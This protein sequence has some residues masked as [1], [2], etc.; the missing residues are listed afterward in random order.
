MHRLF[1]TL[2][3]AAALG[4]GCK[5]EFPNPFASPNPTATP[6][7]DAAVLLTS[8]GYGTAPGAPRDVFAVAA[9]GSG[10]SRL[11]FC[12]TEGRSCDAV[13]A[14]AAPDRAR[15]VVRRATDSNGDGRLTDADDPALVFMDLARGVEAPIVPATARVSGIDWSSQDET[16]FYSAVGAGGLEDL[17]AI[18]TNGQN[19]RALTSSSDA[20]ERRP[21]VNASG[22]ALALE[23]SGS[24]GKT[25]VWIG[26]FGSGLTRVTT[27]GPGSEPLTGTPYV[28]GSDA[29][30]AHS[31]DGRALAFRRLTGTGAGGLGTWDIL[32]VALDGSSPSVIASG[33]SYRGAPD[34]GPLGIVFEEIGQDGA[35]ALVV[36]QPGGS[37]RRTLVTLG[38][39]FRLSFPRWLT[40]R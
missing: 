26:V 23:R 29:D 35:P 34:W 14:A 19:N 12:N 20:R 16:L 21:R 38:P 40:P 31:P 37:G 5:T 24:D 18:D 8:D 2:L 33:P 6:R 3:A 13:E 17:W 22:T 36:V 28:V 27:G 25:E 4:S 15:I 7:P 1:P 10:L 32:T 9:D 39:G 11:S 30:P